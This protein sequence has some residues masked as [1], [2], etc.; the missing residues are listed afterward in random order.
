[1]RRASAMPVPGVLPPTRPRRAGSSSSST[2][3]HP[4]SRAILPPL[5][6]TRKSL[7]D[8]EPFSNGSS[9]PTPNGIP[10]N[11]T[12]LSHSF[13]L[14]LI[15]N[16]SSKLPICLLSIVIVPRI[17]HLCFST[18]HPHSCAC[19]LSPTHGFLSSP[20]FTGPHPHMTRHRARLLPHTGSR[21]LHQAHAP[22]SRRDHPRLITARSL[23]TSST[24]PPFRPGPAPA[25]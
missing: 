9:G 4:G 6:T 18:L 21:P 3:K 19:T 13:F 22:S 15:Y 16:P 24:S 17:S 7:G 14:I 23:T 2:P 10:V 25:P 20:G 1:M 12:V 5:G 11:H 8:R